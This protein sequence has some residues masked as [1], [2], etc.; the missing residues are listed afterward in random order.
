MNAKELS[1]LNKLSL[2]EKVLFIKKIK[3][4]IWEWGVYKNL[5][6]SFLEV[7]GE[8]ASITY[9]DG[10]G[11]LMV[12]K[13]FFYETS[14][15]NTL[16]IVINSDYPPEDRYTLGIPFCALIENYESYPA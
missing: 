10:L 7:C 15:K 9:P 1:N 4:N 11:K 2:R 16:G 14:Y 8:K 13:I 6:N 5:D 12:K 3:G